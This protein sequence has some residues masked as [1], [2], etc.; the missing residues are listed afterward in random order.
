MSTCY[1]PAGKHNLMARWFVTRTIW[2]GAARNWDE[3]SVCHRPASTFRT[4]AEQPVGSWLHVAAKVEPRFTSSAGRPVSVLKTRL[5][6]EREQ[7]RVSNGP[8]HDALCI[9]VAAETLDIFTT[10]CL[11]CCWRRVSASGQNETL[12]W[13]H[14]AARLF[15][16]WKHTTEIQVSAVLHH[17]K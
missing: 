15:K 7:H 17:K 6:S 9:W 13:H 5:H 2:K 16:M 12:C 3:L 10:S 14:R 1:L 4:T 8:G 11:R